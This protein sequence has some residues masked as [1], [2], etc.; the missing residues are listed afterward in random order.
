[1][2]SAYSFQDSHLLHKPSLCHLHFISPRLLSGFIISQ[3]RLFSRPL[4]RHCL[5]FSHLHFLL[6]LPPAGTSYFSCLTLHLC[7]GLD[8]GITSSPVQVSGTLT[9]H[10]I[11][12]PLRT[13]PTHSCQQMPPALTSLHFCISAFLCISLSALLLGFCT[14]SFL[15]AVYSNTI[16][17]PFSYHAFTVSCINAA[18]SG[19]LSAPAYAVSG[20]RRRVG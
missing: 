1:M 2:F 9:L 8:L 13:T 12:L 16:T 7:T 3:D 15:C 17:R 5:T 14:Y 6:C 18:H 10:C 4:H 19:I 20:S 11:Y